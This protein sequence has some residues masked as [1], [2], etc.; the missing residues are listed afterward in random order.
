MIQPS[1]AD[2]DE[3]AVPASPGEISPPAAVSA[4]VHVDLAARTHQG[5]VRENN[6]DHYL[7]TR[8]ERSFQAMMTNLPE[9]L[10]PKRFTEVGYGMLVADGM[11]GRA[12]GEVA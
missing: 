6:E 12:G 5:K 9:G 11:G 7:V 10:I 1:S 8:V 3:Y 2:T 4:N